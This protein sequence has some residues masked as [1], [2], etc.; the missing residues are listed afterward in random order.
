MESIRSFLIEGS[1]FK[2]LKKN[3]VPLTPEERATCMKAKA[4]WHGGPNGEETCAI[5]KSKNV[6]GK[7]TFV[8]NTHRAYNTSTTLNGAIGRFHSFIKDTA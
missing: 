5:W 2:Q 7:F 8:T 1:M 3:R 6:D 4:V